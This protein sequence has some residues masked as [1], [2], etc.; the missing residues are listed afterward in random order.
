MYKKLMAELLGA[1]ALTLFGCG[2]I[3]LP[4]GSL[5]TVTIAAIFGLTVCLATF[6]AGDHADC[7]YNPVITIAML[8]AG[9][10]SL[11][12][13]EKYIVLQLIGAFLGIGIVYAIAVGAPGYDVTTQGL[14]QNGYGAASP[15]NYSMMSCFIAEFSV[16]FFYIQVV[17][18]I[19]AVT[20]SL[21]FDAVC[22]GAAIV[23]AYL[24]LIPV[25]GG[26]VNPA[27]SIAPGVLVGGIAIRQLWL[28]ILAPTV[29]AALSGLLWRQLSNKN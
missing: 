14:G 10:I 23:V 4:Q 6:V 11:I 12:D 24:L 2:A 5:G 8:V 16:T 7:H 3:V 22:S 26:S 25:T 21:L 19:R 15:A 1:M 9:R 20:V 17:L 27:R 28:F 29:G 13:A 18:S